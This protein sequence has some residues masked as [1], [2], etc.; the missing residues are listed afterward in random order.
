MLICTI[1]VTN[2]LNKI[3]QLQFIAAK[4]KIVENNMLKI[5]DVSAASI[6]LFLLNAYSNRVII[7]N[8]KKN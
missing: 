6:L 2:N 3:K 7:K 8:K 5:W 4:L 1:S